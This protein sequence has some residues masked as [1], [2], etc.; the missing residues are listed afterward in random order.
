MSRNPNAPLNDP[1]HWDRFEDLTPEQMVHWDRDLGWFV[2]DAQ[3]RT[4]D[5]FSGCVWSAVA[6]VPCY[7]GPENKLGLCYLYFEGHGW[8]DR[9]YYFIVCRIISGLK[10]MKMPWSHADYRNY[11]SGWSG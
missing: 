4:C 3:I 2:R 8:V 5:G 6:W 10:L 1:D 9:V 11:P 7:G